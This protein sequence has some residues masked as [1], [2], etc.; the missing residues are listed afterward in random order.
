[1]VSHILYIIFRIRYQVCVTKILLN[2]NSLLTQILYYFE[3]QLRF[4]FVE[5]FCGLY[6]YIK[7]FNFSLA[8]IDSDRR[9]T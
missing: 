5:H 1:M 3:T 6:E 2:I 4:L 9:D 7:F 8:K